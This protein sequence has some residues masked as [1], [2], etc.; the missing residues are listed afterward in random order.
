MVDSLVAKYEVEAV[1]RAIGLM[2]SVYGEEVLEKLQDPEGGAAYKAHIHDLVNAQPIHPCEAADK[3][4]LDIDEDAPPPKCLSSVVSSFDKE[5]AFAIIEATSIAQ[6]YYQHH[7][8]ET[9][10]I[11]ATIA[12]DLLEAKKGTSSHPM[13][14]AILREASVV[15]L[16]YQLG[17]KERA[18]MIESAMDV[19]PEDRKRI[20]N[21]KNIY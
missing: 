7:D 14:E 17:L 18:A 9:S 1:Q 10:K 5:D 15:V 8:V 11:Y 6:I 13:D 19:R 16:L 21:A 12:A 2:D 3:L 20:E 4:T